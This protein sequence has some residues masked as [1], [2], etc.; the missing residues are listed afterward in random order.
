MLL[1]ISMLPPASYPNKYVGD[2]IVAFWGAPIPEE[3]HAYLE[4]KTLIDLQLLSEELNQE[5]KDKG[6]DL[7][8]VIFASGANPGTSIVGNMGRNM[9]M[10][11]SVL[12]DSVNLAARLESETRKQNTPIIIREYTYE[13]VK[14]RILY[15]D[16]GVIS[17]K[18]K[19]EKVGIFAPTFDGVIK[20]LSY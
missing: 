1:N 5:I 2:C 11:Y 17:V 10:N 19:K 7:P 14:D 4:T 6:L 13:K 20:K 16:L 9:R 12:G 8:P 3:D 15:A 18:G